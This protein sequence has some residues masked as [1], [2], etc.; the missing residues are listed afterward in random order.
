M[1]YNADLNMERMTHPDGT[2]HRFVY[3]ASGNR[4]TEIDAEGTMDEVYQR[5]LG[6]L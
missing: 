5:L 6:A 3:D 1:T 2:V 4:I